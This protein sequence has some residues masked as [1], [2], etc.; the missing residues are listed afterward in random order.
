MRTIV[1][2][3]L[4]LQLIS[5]TVGQ[6]TKAASPPVVVAPRG[7]VT[8]LISPD[9]KWKLVFECPDFDRLRQ[10]WIERDGT[11][12]RRLVREYERSVDMGWAPDSRMFFVND[13]LGSDE[14]RPYLYDPVT[15]QETDLEQ[16]LLAGDP[17]ADEYLRT[18]HSYLQVRRWVTSNE[19][20]V[21]LRGHFDEDP[22][23]AFMLRYR[24]QISGAVR[25]L[26]KQEYY[27]G[28]PIR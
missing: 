28:V 6:T 11:G 8:H 2:F 14:A 7:Q 27:N 3:L 5:P 20:L 25:R 10:L 13:D 12:T 15:L 24:V 18:G 16:V 4:V 1:A 21:T 22:Y 17:T 19:L 26:F 23:R 9:R